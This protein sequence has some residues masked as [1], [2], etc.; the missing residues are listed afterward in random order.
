MYL[1]TCVCHLWRSVC[2]GL[3]SIFFIGLFGFLLLSCMS[4]LYILEINPLSVALFASIFSH[5]E[6]YLLI[7]FVSFAAQKLLSLTRSHLFVFIF[8]SLG[9]GS[10]KIFLGFTSECSMFSSKSFMVSGLTV[11]YISKCC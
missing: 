5:S 3:P 10:K 2:S 8:I 1:L 7:L 9:G 4:Y 6:G 11:M